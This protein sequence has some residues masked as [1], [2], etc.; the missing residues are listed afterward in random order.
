MT[1][2][3]AIAAAR[4]ELADVAV[5]HGQHAAAVPAVV[6]KTDRHTEDLDP[7]ALGFERG[8]LEC[9]SPRAPQY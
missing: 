7:L 5:A 8:D 6:T 9:R 1:T 2:T 3:G 4:L